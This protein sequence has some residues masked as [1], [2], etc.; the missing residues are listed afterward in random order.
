MDLPVTKKVVW[1]TTSNEPD[2][3]NDLFTIR[4]QLGSSSDVVAETIYAD[5][6]VKPTY[7]LGDGVYVIYLKD[8]ETATIRE[9]PSGTHWSIVEAMP[10]MG[11]GTTDPNGDPITLPN[12]DYSNTNKAELKQG[13]ILSNPGM[14]PIK[15]PIT[16]ENHY[17][18]VKKGDLSIE[19]IFE[20]G[21]D[22]LPE[23]V[24]VQLYRNGEPHESPIR[25]EKGSDGRFTY[26]WD[27][28][29]LYDGDGGRR[30][31]YTV[32]EVTVTYPTG[33]G[34]SVDARDGNIIRVRGDAATA[35]GDREILGGWLVS[36]SGRMFA[37]VTSNTGFQNTIAL[38]NTWIPAH[39]VGQIGHNVQKVDSETSAP[40]SGVTFTLTSETHDAYKT[41]HPLTTDA[42]GKVSFGGLK[43]GT[44]TLTE[45][46]AADGYRYDEDVELSWAINVSRSGE[47]LGVKDLTGSSAGENTW[48][49]TVAEVKDNVLT[50]TNE[51][52]TGKIS[53]TKQI[54]GTDSAAVTG[55]TFTFQVKDASGQV[56]KTL[57]VKA[58]ETKTVDGLRYG[59]YT[60]TETGSSEVSGFQ[61]NGITWSGDGA[62]TGTG[63]SI[64]VEVDEHD[65]TYA[66]TAENSYTEL[67]GLSLT[68]T[69]TGGRGE[70]D[71][72]W[73]FILTLTGNTSRTAPEFTFSGASSESA[74]LVKGEDLDR[75]GN[76]TYTVTM[77]GGVTL[78][79]T[80]LSDGTEYEVYEVEAN[81][82]GYTTSAEKDGVN[83]PYVDGATDVGVDIEQDEEYS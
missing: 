37:A 14:E 27:Q 51:P 12:N 57:T 77:K 3:E 43:E 15:V 67:G 42:N 59:R 60:V 13:G 2:L 41:G 55:R 76:G 1:N 82:D 74:S 34:W 38:K 53:I 28:L 46:K 30:Y 48:G 18:N 22:H 31:D 29:P 70:A 79:V 9:I 47:L 45:T 58:G 56:V 49:L 52:I 83:V 54:T 63:D 36:E 5:N 19:K 16:V 4:V 66:V 7:Y 61:Y 10:S 33:S 24:T 69:V 68:K 65:K 20:G 62:V 8:G 44:Y 81:D 35:D 11:T 6:A 32:K 21:G 80:G 40:I 25:I 64:Q 71:R 39:N 23:S 75:Y 50:I 72:D 17:F 78:Q 73:N 26:T